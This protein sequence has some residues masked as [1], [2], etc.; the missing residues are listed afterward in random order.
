MDIPTRSDMV[1]PILT[2]VNDDGEEVHRKRVT[3]VLAG[4]FASTDEEKK[5]LLETREIQ[6][7]GSTKFVNEVS[8]AITWLLRADLL[9]RPK[10]GFY[11]ITNLGRELLRT[12]SE[13]DVWG[14]V[15]EMAKV[16]TQ[17][18]KEKA[19]KEKVAP[20]KEDRIPMEDSD[21]WRGALLNILKNMSPDAFERLCKEL[22]EKAGCT[23]VEIT[24]GPGDNGIDGRAL[25]DLKGLL[26]VT[27][28]FQCKRVAGTISPRVVRDFRGAIGGSAAKGIIFTTGR[29]S[30]NAQEEAQKV[31]TTPIALI[32]GELLTQ[33]M[34]ELGLGVSTKKETVEIEAVS[35]DEGWFGSL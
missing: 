19:A 18:R 28:L 5:A 7:G 1:R 13:A 12:S 23:Q 24:G 2:M 34:K 35:V 25:I 32:D 17:A 29:F 21:A 9:E 16:R 8:W 26:S 11:Q 20:I 4:L 27:V 31:G 30:R 33:K 15:D 10:R 6:S 3:E 14:K 22:L